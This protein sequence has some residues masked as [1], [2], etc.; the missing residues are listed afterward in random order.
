MSTQLISSALEEACAP[1][2][3]FLTF[4]Q[5]DHIVAKLRL[6]PQQARIVS[7]ILQDKQD[8]EIARILGMKKPTVRT[9]LARIF[10]RIGVNDRMGVA[11]FIFAECMNVA[12]VSF[13]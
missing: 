13:I 9:Y 1:I 7:L 2:P 3:P 6:S 4:E 5:W 10:Q 8:K 11:L 12:G